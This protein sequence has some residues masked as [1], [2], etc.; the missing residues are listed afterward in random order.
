MVFPSNPEFLQTPRLAF[1]CWRAADDALALSL[2]QD[3]D[4]MRY[5]GGPM[6][7]AE[8]QARLQAE[9]DRQNH[10]GFQ[11]WPMFLRETGAFA[12]C[13]G[14][15]PFHDEAGVMEMGIHVARALWG[16]RLGEEATRAIIAYAF[17]NVGARAL[18]A[19]HH[20]ENAN[21]KALLLRL[22]FVYTHDEIW[23]RTGQSHPFYRLEPPTHTTT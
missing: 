11:Y 23:I 7:D 6:T 18:T 15:K 14:L 12:G 2:W 5:I 13:C 10:F 20:P 1:R 4:V 8:V 19:A 3:A 21:S 22:G 16:A 9:M 17:S